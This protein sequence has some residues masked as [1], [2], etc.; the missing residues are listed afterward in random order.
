MLTIIIIDE[1]LICDRN[2]KPVNDWKLNKNV[3]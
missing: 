1:Y 3:S 2:Q